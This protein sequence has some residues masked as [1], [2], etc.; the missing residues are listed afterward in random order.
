MLARECAFNDAGSLKEAL[1]LIS[2]SLE[3][4][5]RCYQINKDAVISL[6]LCK[7]EENQVIHILSVDHSE[8]VLSSI[9][10]MQ[11]DILRDLGEAPGSVNRWK[12]Y[13][14]NRANEIKQFYHQSFQYIDPYES[15]DVDRRYVLYQKFISPYFSLM[16][17]GFKKKM[18]ESLH[19]E[20]EDAVSEAHVHGV[21]SNVIA[22]IGNR[23]VM[24][25]DEIKLYS[26]RNRE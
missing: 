18:F 23:S 14:Y 12:W 2:L 21:Y 13:I 11:S 20:L 8:Q 7:D 10:V 1:D 19:D 6:H 25:P 5:Q 17:T 26:N 4:E 9:D 22:I 3:M 15:T 24:G 16:Y